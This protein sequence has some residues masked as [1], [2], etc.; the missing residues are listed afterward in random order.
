MK[1][2]ATYPL[3]AAPARVFAML[4]D[5]AVLKRCIE[6][7]EQLEQTA[8]DTYEVR[9]LVGLAALK[10]TYR[11][12]IR[13][14]EKTPPRALSLDVEGK[15]SAGFVRG[16][17]RIELTEAPNGTEVRCD[18]D[19]QVGGLIA[20]VGSRL[21]DAAGRRMMDRFFETL[22]AEVRAGGPGA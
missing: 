21:V 2:S 3:P 19:G 20:A 7:C 15:G 16:R 5:P 22:S 10:G 8:D 4:T 9:L 17:A 14:L 6:G 13:I 12:T 18:G 1:L 11:G